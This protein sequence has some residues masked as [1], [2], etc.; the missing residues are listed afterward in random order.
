MDYSLLLLCVGVLYAGLSIARRSFGFGVLAAVAANGGLWFFL[1]RQEGWGFLAHPQVWLIPPAVCVLVAA[2][3]NRRQ[4]SESQM[5]AIR[6]ATSMAIY[7]SSTADIFLNGVAQAPM[8]PLVLA[9]LSI[10][11]IAA[12]IVLRVRAFLFLGTGFLALAMFTIIWHAAVDRD[13]TWIWWVSGIVAGLLIYMLVAI[14]EKK[15]QQVLEVVDRIK[16][17]EA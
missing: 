17:W 15:R 8:L 10:L 13:Q 7:M 1:N 5:T 16:Q 6:Y 4:L 12:G 3:I 9:G 11:G 14:F 2:Y